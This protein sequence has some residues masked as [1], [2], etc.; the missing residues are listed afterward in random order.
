MLEDKQKPSITSLKKATLQYGLRKLSDFE[1]YK[2]LEMVEDL[3]NVSDHLKD[4]KAD[5]Y[6]TVYSIFHERIEKTPEHFKAYI[7]SLLGDKDYDKIVE[8]VSKVDRAIEK[9]VALQGT[10]ASESTPPLFPRGPSF[11]PTP[12][13]PLRSFPHPPPYIGLP[14]QHSYYPPPLPV[15]AEIQVF[16]LAS[17]VALRVTSPEI[18][19]VG[20]GNLI[21]MESLNP[22]I[23]N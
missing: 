12:P 20:E 15:E 6:K 21:R 16:L 19:T 1:K 11:T 2:A 3:K 13:L 5:Y 17:F 23:I 18:A 10:S 22:C 14:P 7:L 8:S 9:G 4:R